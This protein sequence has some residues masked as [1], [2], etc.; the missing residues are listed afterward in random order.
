MRIEIVQGEPIEGTLLYVPDEY[1]FQ[2][3]MLTQTEN[4]GSILINDLQIEV[5]HEGLLLYTWG[6]CP[7]SNW[8]DMDAMFP[9]VINKKRLCIEKWS[10][11][12]GV[13]IRCNVNKWTVK[14]NRSTGWICLGPHDSAGEAIYF[15]P[16]SVAIL[17]K[18]EIRALW[19]RPDNSEILFKNN[20]GAPH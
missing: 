19:L 15:A 12:P 2:T 16:G 10:N 18:Y 1:S 7:H 17:D 3:N 5:D 14:A 4:Y 11:P 9:N 6:Y 13:S 20:C 8:K